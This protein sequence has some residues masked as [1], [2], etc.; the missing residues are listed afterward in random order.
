MVTPEEQAALDWQAARKQRAA[1][2]RGLQAKLKAPA[3]PEAQSKKNFAPLTKTGTI[4]GQ[5]A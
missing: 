3:G 5:L 2:E 4:K 1:F